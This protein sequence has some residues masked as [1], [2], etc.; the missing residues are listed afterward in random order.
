MAKDI[1]L[2]RSGIVGTWLAVFGVFLALDWYRPTIELGPGTG[3]TLMITLFLNITIVYGEWFVLRER[4]QGTFAFLRRFPVSD[5]QIITSKFLLM[6]LLLAGGFVLATAA[7]ARRYLSWEWLPV[8]SLILLAFA[9][10]GSLTVATRLI[11]GTRWG[12]GLPYVI[13]FIPIVAFYLL[14]E[15]GFAV[16]VVLTGLWE[17]GILQWI[18]ALAGFCAIGVLWWLSIEYFHSR[19]SAQLSEM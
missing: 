6:I 1:R 5:A 11:F 3:L 18:L 15:N 12:A 4:T 17:A 7:G 9:V 19:D 16:I 10:F 14:K 2:Y 13:A 8:Y